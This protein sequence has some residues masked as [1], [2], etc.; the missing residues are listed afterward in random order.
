MNKY[1]IKAFKS[2]ETIQ[3]DIVEIL[4][5][6]HI[7]FYIQCEDGE[8]E[9]VAA[10]PSDHSFQKIENKLSQKEVDKVIEKIPEY[11][12]KTVA[13]SEADHEKIPT[14][15]DPDD[16]AKDLMKQFEDRKEKMKVETKH[17]RKMHSALDKFREAELKKKLDAEL[18]FTNDARTEDLF[19]QHKLSDNIDSMVDRVQEYNKLAVLPE[20]IEDKVK[21]EVNEPEETKGSI[22]DK[23]LQEVNDTE[24]SEWVLE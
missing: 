13:V 2:E 5:T 3:A 7:A 1:K 24:N 9:L 23:E 20:G 10:Y 6:G 11:I 17:Y 4:E 18:S 14:R 16:A 19:N 15:Y 12:A 8:F 21:E 22:T